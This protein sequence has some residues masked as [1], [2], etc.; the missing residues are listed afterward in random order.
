M[1]RKGAKPI[2]DVEP[3]TARQTG[4]CMAIERRLI[5]PL[6]LRPAQVIASTIAAASLIFVA[7][8]ALS[9]NQSTVRATD[10]IMARK[11][12][13]D[14][15]SDKMDALELMVAQGKIN[16][17]QG[18]A[19]ANDISVYLMAFPHMFPPETNQWKPGVAHDP[20]ADTAAAPEVW[21]KFDD[22]YRQADAASKAAY[23]ASRTADDSQFKAAVSALRTDCNTCHAAYFKMD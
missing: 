21:T 13:M 22:F 5:A 19:D 11:T 14:T 2:G 18:H 10:A 9:Q 7:S 1:W 6:Y 16:L 20:I 12:V 17:E 23:D 8:A 3:S 15:L 4:G